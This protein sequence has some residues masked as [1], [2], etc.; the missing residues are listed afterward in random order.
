MGVWES[1]KALCFPGT[2]AQW[3]LSPWCYLLL[4]CTFQEDLGPSLLLG[5]SSLWVLLAASPSAAPL[6]ASSRTCLSLWVSHWQTHPWEEWLLV[7]GTHG[8]Q[9]GSSAGNRAVSPPVPAAQDGDREVG[10]GPLQCGEGE[11][12]GR[13]GRHSVQMK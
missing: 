2:L 8:C 12:S 4:T 3:T 5:K 7:G 1:H 6:Q 9:S 11:A 13:K 10:S